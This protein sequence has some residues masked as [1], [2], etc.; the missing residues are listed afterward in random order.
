MIIMTNRITF[1][2]LLFTALEG[3]DYILLKSIEKNITKIDSSSDLDIWWKNKKDDFIADFVN[4]HFLV[5][6]FTSNQQS[7]MNQY[8]IFFKDGGFL[9]IDCLYK[10]I[11][12]DLVYLSNDYLKT[13]Q[14]T[15][16]GIK[17]YTDSVSYT[18]LTLPT[19]A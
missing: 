7:S 17:I 12:K 19:K 1:I 16:H 4:D 3:K 14:R 13:Q 10:L 6:K 8:F 18:H 5:E 15:K 9:Q 11:R 2:K